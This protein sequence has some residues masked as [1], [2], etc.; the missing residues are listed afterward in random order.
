[1]NH[2]RTYSTMCAKKVEVLWEAELHSVLDAD[3]VK[4]TVADGSGG[5]RR[6]LRQPWEE[7]AYQG[8]F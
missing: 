5:T 3:G 8:G 6:V 1:M 2:R 4:G 7:A